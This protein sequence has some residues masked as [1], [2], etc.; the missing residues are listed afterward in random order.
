MSPSERTAAPLDTSAAARGSRR[1]QA[2]R[3]KLLDAAEELLATADPESI[4]MD[5]I[6]ALAGVSR[7]SAFGHFGTK[8]E[9]VSASMERL[10]GL[11]VTQLVTAFDSPGTPL[12]QATAGGTAYIDLL[13]EHPALTR[14]LTVRSARSARSPVD[15][16]IRRQ[17]EELRATFEARLAAAEETAAF[18]A[19]ALSYFLFSSWIGT[20]ALALPAASGRPTLSRD[21]A[22]AVV[23]QVL[24]LMVRGFRL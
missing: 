16:R 17:L 23:T 19:R 12:E 9:L 15:Q 11:V 13:I 20:A 7:A 24:D 8:D 21:E 4:R 6:A 2:T 10:L 3:T 18:D 5:E 1:Q 22:H 14:Y